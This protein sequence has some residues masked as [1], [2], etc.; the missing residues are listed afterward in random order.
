MNFRTE[1]RNYLRGIGYIHINIDGD[2]YYH[3]DGIKVYG[4]G[5]PS[6]KVVI[7]G[8]D[9]VSLNGEEIVDNVIYESII[10]VVAYNTE[11]I[12]ESMIDFESVIRDIEIVKLGIL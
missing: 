10:K 7:A 3:K 11:Y 2:K 12:I 5:E 8:K 1:L 9:G 4:V 6:A